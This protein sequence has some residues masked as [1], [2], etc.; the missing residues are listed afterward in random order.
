[1]KEIFAQAKA[2]QIW[3]GRDFEIK[4][5]KGDIEGALQIW[6]DLSYRFQEDTGINPSL[7]VSRNL[8]WKPNSLHSWN[9][10]VS[11]SM[12]E[13]PATAEKSY[14]P[15]TQVIARLDTSVFLR[16]PLS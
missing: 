16:P 2:V 13:H 3:L 4:E 6:Q 11:T 1:M 8:P 9:P 12:V 10:M 14:I 5:S 7:L 15:A